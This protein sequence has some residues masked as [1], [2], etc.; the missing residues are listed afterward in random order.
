MTGPAISRGS[1]TKTIQR[2]P[3][4]AWICGLGGISILGACTRPSMLQ[5]ASDDRV[6]VE[7]TELNRFEPSGLTVPVGSSI[8]W[9]NQSNLPHTTTCDPALVTDTS[10]VRL[11]GEAEPWDSG[12][13]LPGRTWAHTFETPGRYV[14]VCRW[15]EASGMI[16]TI[17]VE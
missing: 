13:V 7:M 8:V 1:G 16:G 17:T 15:H 12:D 14:Y 4:L 2:R 9:L 11:P 3:V 5:K 6:T 10:A